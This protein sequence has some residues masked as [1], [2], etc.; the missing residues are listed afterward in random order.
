[1]EVSCSCIFTSFSRADKE[2]IDV[3]SFKLTHFDAVD[4]VDADLS[5]ALEQFNLARTLQFNAVSVSTY[6][7]L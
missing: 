4:A 5:A 7:Q 6:E 3:G 2:P 1:M